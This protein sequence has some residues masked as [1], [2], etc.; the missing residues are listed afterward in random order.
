MIITVDPGDREPPYQQIRVQIL[1]AI[2]AG[3]LVSSS[4]LPTIRQLASDLDLAV[5]TVARAY[6]ELEAEGA[7]E[8]RGRKGSFI[9]E[10][11]SSDAAA[12]VTRQLDA[13]ARSCVTAARDLGATPGDIAH[14]LAR[15]LAAPAAPG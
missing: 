15:A 8:T 10:P 1:E 5:N 2:T 4:R 9:C 12:A 14:A 7:I 11:G 6:R 13:I 3:T